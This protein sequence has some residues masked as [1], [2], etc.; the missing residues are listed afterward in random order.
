MRLADHTLDLVGVHLAAPPVSQIGDSAEVVLRLVDSDDVERRADNPVAQR[1]IEPQRF[2]IGCI[3][4]YDFYFAIFAHINFVLRF[5]GFGLGDGFRLGGLKF[6]LGH[7]W[8]P[9]EV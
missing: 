7:D 8:P 5:G 2:D 6:G 4:W 9:F 3:G 1:R